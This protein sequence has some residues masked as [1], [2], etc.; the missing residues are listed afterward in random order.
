MDDNHIVF[1]NDVFNLASCPSGSCLGYE[2]RISFAYEGPNPAGVTVKNSTFT[3]GCADGVQFVG[4]AGRGVTIGP[5][6]TFTNL[7]QGSCAP[8]VD[9]DPV[10]QR[11]RRDDHRQLLLQHHHGN[12]QL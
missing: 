9:S 5:G 2:G 7:L 10:R 11:Q 3:S 12:R 4:S 8:H 1:D 6:N